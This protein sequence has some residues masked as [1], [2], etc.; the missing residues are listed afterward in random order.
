MRVLA[1]ASYTTGSKDSHW[2]FWGFLY[3]S[4]AFL[5][6]STE[7]EL[8][9]WISTCLPSFLHF[10]ECLI[11]LWGSGQC[12]SEDDTR[13]HSHKVLIWPSWLV[14]ADVV[15]DGHLG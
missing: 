3:A 1:A 8:G 5:S 6:Y 7:L 10:G 9:E 11:S 13:L 14:V 2:I 12:S 15:T 4:V